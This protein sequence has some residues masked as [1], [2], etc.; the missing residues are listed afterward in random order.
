MLWFLLWWCLLVGW[1]LNTCRALQNS[2]LSG[3]KFKSEGTFSQED[4]TVKSGTFHIMFM[5]LFLLMLLRW[6][7]MLFSL[8]FTEGRAQCHYPLETSILL[9]NIPRQHKHCISIKRKQEK[10]S[11]LS[12]NFNESSSYVHWQIRNIKSPIK[13]MKSELHFKS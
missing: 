4:W 5:F 7:T 12:Q 13:R 8:P 10:M 9:R 3:H 2:G 1:C 6:K 11:F